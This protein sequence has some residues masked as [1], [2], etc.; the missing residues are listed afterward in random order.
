MP[1]SEHGQ[2][3]PVAL[4]PAGGVEPPPRPQAQAARVMSRPAGGPRRRSGRRRWPP[5]APHPA[6]AAH[7]AAQADQIV[8]RAVNAVVAR[9][10]ALAG[11]PQHLL[12]LGV[13]QTL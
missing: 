7:V 6:Q 4:S 10:P 9:A 5:L 8:L 13:A 3:E 2:G 1:P 12:G 11:Q